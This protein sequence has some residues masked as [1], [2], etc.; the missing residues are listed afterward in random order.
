MSLFFKAILLDADRQTNAANKTFEEFLRLSRSYTEFDEAILSW[1]DHQRL[2]RSVYEFLIFR[3]VT[4]EG[5]EESIQT[6][7]PLEHLMRY[8]MDPDPRDQFASLF[9]CFLSRSV[10]GFC[11]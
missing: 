7:I 11:W 8:L 6:K 10:A 9:F 2:R 1:A 5:R 3:G 4:F